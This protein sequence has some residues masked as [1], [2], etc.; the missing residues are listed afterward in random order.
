MLFVFLKG[1]LCDFLD[2]LV[3][4]LPFHG[5]GAQD[6]VLAFGQHK[7]KMMHAKEKEHT[8]FVTHFACRYPDARFICIYEF[9]S[10]DVCMYFI[11]LAC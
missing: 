4:V 9:V 7:K 8:R 10:Y 3:L 5:I 11:Q 6:K 2:F 1:T